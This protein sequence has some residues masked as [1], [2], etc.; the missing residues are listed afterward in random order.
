MND[1][2]V[3]KLPIARNFN[4]DEPIKKEFHSENFN[5]SHSTLV[6]FREIEISKNLSGEKLN[7]NIEDVG[8]SIENSLDRRLSDFQRWNEQ[9]DARYERR[10]SESEERYAR[11]TAEA[12]ARMDKQRQEAESRMERQCKEADER[13]SAQRKEDKDH[14]DSALSEMRADNK[15]T[16]STV[17]TTA[18]TSSLAII[19]GVAGLVGVAVSSFQS[20]VSEQGSWMR[21]SIDRQDA[22]QEKIDDRMSSIETSIHAIQQ[23][24]NQ[25]DSKK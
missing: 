6:D 20:T 18:I 25:Q 21:Q 9:A 15:S 4:V 23:H 19:F 8:S 24:L 3:V 12:E 16:R 13:F 14:L 10:Q 22:R 5:F 1:S 17:I 11:R 7:R 2:N